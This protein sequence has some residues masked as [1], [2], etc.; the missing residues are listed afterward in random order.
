MID[1]RRQH[2][3]V[4]FN[5]AYRQFGQR[6]YGTAMRMLR[7]SE[8]AEDAVQE[9]FLTLYRKKPEIPGPQLG[10]WLHRV[11]VNHCIDRTRHG[12]RWQMDELGER[13]T[14]NPGPRE[15]LKLD[16]ESAVALLPERARLV[17]LLHDVEGFGHR[18]VGRMLDLTEGTSKSQLFR[19]R[20]LLRKSMGRATRETS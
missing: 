12:K 1:S 4:A 7:R 19:A 18:E 17:F 5:D 10:A 8:D 9:A 6:L 20:R 13:A 2:E 15:G 11:L 14:S 3:T 16:L